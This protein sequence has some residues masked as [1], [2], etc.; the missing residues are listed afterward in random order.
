[1]ADGAVLSLLDLDP[2][3]LLAALATLPALS[4]ATARAACKLFAVIIDE[5]SRTTSFL[6]SSVGPFQSI[7]AEV[8]PQL[9]AQPTLGI[10]FSKDLV[11]RGDLQCLANKLPYH[12]EVRT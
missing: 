11:S 2:E 1:M 10:L 12:L 4:H 6:T 5:I 8:S 3:L 9:E 7:V